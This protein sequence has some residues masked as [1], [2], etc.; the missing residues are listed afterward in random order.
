MTPPKSFE[1]GVFQGK[2]EASIQGIAEGL[3]AVR[4]NMARLPCEKHTLAM[5][6]LMVHGYIRWIIVVMILSG[7]GYLYDRILTLT[8][9]AAT[10]T[11]QMIEVVDKLKTVP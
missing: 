3:D 7:V 5:K 10:L 8:E 1:N 2:T 9:R 4:S 11:T 6:S